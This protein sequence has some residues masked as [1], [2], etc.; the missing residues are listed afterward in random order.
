MSRLGSN[1]DA[2]AR[3]PICRACGNVFVPPGH[4]GCCSV[5][6]VQYLE[7]ARQPVL[8]DPVY[9]QRDEPIKCWGCEVSFMSRGLR[10]CPECYFKV[11]TAGIGPAKARSGSIPCAEFSADG[12][13]AE[14]GV[15]VG[16]GTGLAP[17]ARRDEPISDRDPRSKFCHW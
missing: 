17:S 12:G 9:C 8:G 2:Y 1:Y 4:G 11:R 6:C 3:F 7:V 16:V 14:V 15:G 10:Y 5:R 13:E